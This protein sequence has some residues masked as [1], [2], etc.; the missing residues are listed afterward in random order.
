MSSIPQLTM[1]KAMLSLL[2]TPANIHASSTN[3]LDILHESTSVCKKYIFIK[4]KKLK[5]RWRFPGLDIEGSF[6]RSSE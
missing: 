4:D 6:Y 3:K 5:W 1:V 2:H